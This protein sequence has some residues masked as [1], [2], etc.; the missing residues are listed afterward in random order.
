MATPESLN[1]LDIS[2][3]Y[4]MNKTL[5]DDNSDE[6][7]RLQGVSWFKRRAISLGT[8][9]LAVK[10]YKEDEIEHIDIDQTLTGGIPGT[11]EKRTLIWKERKNEDHLFGAVIGKS[12]RTKADVFDEDFLKKGWTEDTLDYGV[13]QSYVESDTAK[14]GTTWIANQVLM[15]LVQTWGIEV[16]NEERRYT[17]H[18]KFTGPEGQDIEC[19]LVY[20]Y[21]RSDLL[22]RS[23]M[24]ESSTSASSSSS[25]RADVAPFLEE[26]K[27]Q[28][29]TTVQLVDFHS[30]SQLE[31]AL[32]TPTVA[33]WPQETRRDRFSRNFLASHPRMSTRLSRVIKYLKGPRPKVVLPGLSSRCFAQ[34]PL[35]DKSTDPVP[36]LDIDWCTRG[37][38][39][40]LSL[41]STVLKLTRLLTSPWLFLVLG[42]AYIIGFAFFS[43]AESF[44]TPASSFIACNSAYW[45]SNNG[46]GLD[47]ELCG[48]FTNVTLDFRCPAQCDSLILQN[49]R[50]VG[51]DQVAF[52]PLIVGGGDER[53]TYRGDSFICAAANQLGLTTNGKGGC[54]SL[55]L[56]GNFSDFLPTTGNGLASI[57]FP[58]VFPL[59]FRLSKTHTLSH[60]EDNRNGALAFNI[61]ITW[62]LF[63]ILRPRA[64]VLYWSLVCIGFWHISLFSQP[65]ASPPVISDAFGTF[66]PTLFIAY[67]FWRLAFRFTLPAFS[68][69]PLEAS[70]WYL[71]PY[72]AGVLTNIT[73]DKIPISR[74][75]A[76]D[77]SKRSGAITALVIIIIV[78]VI[79]AANQV[80]VMRK[81]G[82]FLHY[83]KWYILGGLVLLVLSQLPGLQLRIHHYIISMALIPGTAFPTRMSAIIQAFL[84]GMFLNG[85]AAFGFDSILQTAAELQ[86]D[87]PSGS[88]LPSFLTNSTNF[89]S[90]VALV[91]QTIT[92]KALAD[93]WDGFSLLVDDVERYAGT[94]L[95]FSLAA[96]DAGIPHFFRLAYTSGDTTGDFTM[97]AVLWPNGTWVDPAPGPS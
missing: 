33:T 27:V 81:T 16:V 40:T 72:W 50:T 55:E 67:A 64:I 3:K 14:S 23:N 36:L 65:R 85:A 49:P 93:S 77:L 86:E 1:I 92:W 68:R 12:R 73:F 43:R 94:A 69:A 79:L 47:G 31:A 95:N 56:V 11:S 9:T 61:I 62:M 30:D 37:I 57:G 88:L 5:S 46:C 28:E 29:E 25:H 38:H 24:A 45:A 52:V 80:R 19:R 66:L 4:T 6:I 76:S 35:T 83:L 13:I 32:R 74:L 78:V 97:P 10:H 26:N 82:W 87:G 44:L 90:S 71:A 17:R 84:L 54:A 63:V 89:N 15:Q 70:V 75:T 41:E 39:I 91:N 60:C 2:G 53:H 20:D 59:A 96:F 8:V 58:T 21:Q 48:P 18:V 42:A 7:L 51:G 34:P 22:Q